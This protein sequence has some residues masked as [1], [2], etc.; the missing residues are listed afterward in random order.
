MVP[1]RDLL[2]H[3]ATHCCKRLIPCG[4]CPKEVVSEQLAWHRHNECLCRIVKCRISCGERMLAKDLDFHEQEVRFNNIQNIYKI[5]Y[6]K[7]IEY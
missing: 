2:D 3:E 6:R 4:I 7:N 5:F 1:I